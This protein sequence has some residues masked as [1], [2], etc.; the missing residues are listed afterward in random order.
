MMKGLAFILVLE[1]KFSKT[2][3]LRIILLP[4][5]ILVAEAENLASCHNTPIY[6]KDRPCDP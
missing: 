1:V 5:L 2:S 4:I 6:R 3:E